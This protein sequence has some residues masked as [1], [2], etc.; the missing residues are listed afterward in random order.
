L[1]LPWK[2]ILVSLVIGLLLGAAGGLSRARELARHWVQ[3][4]PTR[5]LKN[6]DQELHLT[7]S[8]RSQILTLLNNRRDKLIAYEDVVRQETRK[9]IRGQ[10][11]PDQQKKF[12]AFVV[13]HDAE[14]QM[15][16]ER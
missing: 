4:S 1:K 6:L 3:T 5:Y 10:L 16:E 15:A 14:R 12:V 7:E 2:Y 9:E 13:R 11:T 8:Q